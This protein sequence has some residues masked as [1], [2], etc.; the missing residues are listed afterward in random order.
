MSSSSGGRRH[1]GLTSRDRLERL[2][3]WIAG[4]YWL[5]FAAGLAWALTA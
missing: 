2:A 1:D 4:A 3:Y 5:V